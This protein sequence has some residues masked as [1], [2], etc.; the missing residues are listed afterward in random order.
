M[1]ET[2][3]QGLQADGT[4][5]SISK[6]CRWYGEPRRT[7]YYRPVK[8]AQKLQDRLAVRIKAMLEELLSFGYQTVAYLQGSTR[9]PCSASFNTR[10]GRC[11]ST[12]RASGLGSSQ[13]L[14][15][16]R[17]PASAG[18][19]MPGLGR[20]RWLDDEGP[21]DRQPQSR[22]ALEQ[23]LIARFGTLGRVAEPSLLHSENGLVFTSS[24]FTALVNSYGLHQALN[25]RIP[26]EVFSLVA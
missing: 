6:L 1:I 25:M 20:A 13:C 18:L 15:W 7:V 4:T 3:R 8:A 12:L 5:V 11:A 21:G 17:L 14:R 9:T 10:A 26:A 23:A 22:P 16:P 24:S 2:I 19:L